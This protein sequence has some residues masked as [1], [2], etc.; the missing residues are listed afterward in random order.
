[1]LELVEGERIGGGRAACGELRL[2]AEVSGFGGVEED[3]PRERREE[4]DSEVE[5]IEVE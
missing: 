4:R 1:M 5:A 3:V 2:G